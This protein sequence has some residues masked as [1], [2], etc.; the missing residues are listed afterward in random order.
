VPLKKRVFGPGH[1]EYARS[2]HRLAVHLTQQGDAKA[3]LP[4]LKEALKIY[5]ESLGEGHPAWAACCHH[6]ALLYQHLGD[7]KTALPLFKQALEA[8]K[9]AR[10]EKH[11]EYASRLADL[12]AF[13][14]EIGDFSTA[15]PLLR[16]AVAL[17]KAGPGESHPLSAA[18]LNRLASLM[19]DLKDEAEARLLSDKA[20]GF[21]SRALHANALVLSDRQRLAAHASI[22]PLL[23]T[24]LSLP[25]PKAYRHVLA[26]KGA[27]VLRPGRDIAD[28]KVQKLILELQAVTSRLAALSASTTPRQETLRKLTE[29]QERLQAELHRRSARVPSGLQS[30]PPTPKELSG[31]LPDGVVLV[32]YLFYD[33]SGIAFR[34]GKPNPVRHLVAFVSRK[35]KPTIRVDLGP[36]GQVDDALK[37]GRSALVQGEGV[38]PRGIGK[39]PVKLGVTSWQSDKGRAVANLIWSPLA[40]HV[41]G[42][43]VVLVSPD[44]ALATVPFA[45]LPGKKKGTY[46]IEDLAFAV[47]PVPQML[48]E[49]LKQKDKAK[50]LKPSLLVVG[51]VDYAGVATGPDCRVPS[52]RLRRCQSR[53]PPCSRGARSWTSAR[54]WPRKRGY[55]TR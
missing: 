27:A 26:W 28:P 6:L 55:A 25:G 44:S 1:P 42:A 41:E 11:A 23:D 40:K 14:R 8:T 29:E 47:V 46:L 36:A 52:P 9:L 51:D 3:A 32:D 49:M 13:Y 34:D 15:L 43:K 35:G 2:L 5:K 7:H 37:T 10:G 48:P 21:A 33:R 19:L 24:A 12:A 17:H 38:T 4:H 22:R 54:A 16:K 53:S 20:L 50:R 45:A 30:I 39:H 18:T 31:A